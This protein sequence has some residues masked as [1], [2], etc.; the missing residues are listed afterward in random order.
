MRPAYAQAMAWPWPWP[1][2][3]HGQTMAI[4]MAMAT[5]MAVIRPEY[6]EGGRNHENLLFMKKRVWGP[7]LTYFGPILAM[8]MAWSWPWPSS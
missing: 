4:A 1:W 7:I 2:P 6:A 8:V 3:G 5:A